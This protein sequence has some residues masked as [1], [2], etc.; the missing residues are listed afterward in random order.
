MNTLA[1]PMHGEDLARAK[2]RDFQVIY[3]CSFPL[4][5]MVALV[6]RILPK[7][8]PGRRPGVIAEARSM[9]NTIIPFAFMH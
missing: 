9:A 4:F 8:G 2:A 5:L 7:D 6:L 1:K 3:T